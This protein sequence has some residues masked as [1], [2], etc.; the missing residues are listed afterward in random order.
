MD[1]LNYQP[2]S[3]T[4]HCGQFNY[5][6]F[7]I[8]NQL[9]VSAKIICYRTLRQDTVYFTSHQESSEIEYIIWTANTMYTP[10]LYI[11]VDV[12]IYWSLYHV[13]IFHMKALQNTFEPHWQCV[14][15]VLTFEILCTMSI[16]S[17]RCFY[18]KIVKFAR[19]YNL[20]GY[21]Q[22]VNW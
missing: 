7:H 2:T 16:T 3:F 6:E 21:Q 10:Y 13:E 4:F 15:V 12:N 19:P 1:R 11:N 8:I 9:N 17:N 18:L 14:N 5:G 22:H 20:H